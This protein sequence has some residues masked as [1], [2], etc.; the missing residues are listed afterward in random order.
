[1]PN[2]RMDTSLDNTL[3]GAIELSKATWLVALQMADL[4]QPSLYRLK[5]GVV[6]SLV[7]KLELVQEQHHKRT[8]RKPRIVVCYEAGYDGFWIHRTLEECG[9]TCQIMDAASIEVNRRRRRPKTDRLDAAKLVR[10]LMTWHRGERDVC[11]MVRV[12]TRDEEDLRRSHR[13]RRRLIG[14]QT[15]H[16]NRIKGLLFAYGIRDFGCR[17]DRL[18][19]DGLVTGDGRPMPTRLKSELLREIGRL[20]MVREQ[21]AAVEKERDCAPTPCAS[22]EQKRHKLL[23]LRGIGPTLAAIMSREIYYRGFENRRQV[24]SY[25]GLTPNPYSSGESERSHGISK[26]GNTFAR[27]IMIET[28][29]LWLKHQPNSALSLWYNQRTHGIAGRLRRIMIVA[30]ARK[31]AVAL[32]RYL[33]KG[34]VPTGAIQKVAGA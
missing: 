31:L 24:A 1:M 25:I 19:L 3:F 6:D 15:A 13:E 27:Y 9:I 2:D 11:A 32:W 5:G 7:D 21:I 34:L 17:C 23:A 4:E 26:T 33:E 10:V 29:W 18:K 28:A 30:L 12:P 8:G 20:K 16:T 22:S 14:E